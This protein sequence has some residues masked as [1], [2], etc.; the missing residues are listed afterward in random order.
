MTDALTWLGMVMETLNSLEKVWGHPGNSSGM[1]HGQSQ[2]FNLQPI[3]NMC[4]EL[5]RRVHKQG[6]GSLEHLVKFCVEECS[7]ISSSIRREGSLLLCWQREVVQS[8]KR[9]RAKIYFS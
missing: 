7:Q 9:N 8:T 5:M 6:H 4:V 2:S 3:E 1:T